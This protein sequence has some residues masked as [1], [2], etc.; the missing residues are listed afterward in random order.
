MKSW[1]TTFLGIVCLALC[2]FAIEDNVRREAWALRY[3]ENPVALLTV[4]LIG[5]H[6][7]DHKHKEK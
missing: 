6:A 4:G 2:A 7:R 1:R 3:W 5:I